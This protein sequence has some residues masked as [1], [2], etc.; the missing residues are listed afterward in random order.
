MKVNLLHIN[1]K[2]CCYMY[3]SPNKHSM[4]DT[5]SNLNDQNLTINSKIV[6]RES[7]TKFLGVTIDDMLR[8]KPPVQLLKN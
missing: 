7:L 8:W 5:D 6:S 1:V 4:N 3:F 2:K